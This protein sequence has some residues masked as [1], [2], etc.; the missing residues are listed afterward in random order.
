[1]K[2]EKMSRFKV[3][4]LPKT[5]EEPA[6]EPW[7]LTPAMKSYEPSENIKKMAQP[8]AHDDSALI[9]SLPVPIN[10]TALTYKGNTTI[11]L[12]NILIH[13]IYTCIYKYLII[14]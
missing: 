5:L 8:T 7:T 13:S 6:K 9:Q 14:L 12:H 4:A 11:C 1:M 10:P 3:L 2:L